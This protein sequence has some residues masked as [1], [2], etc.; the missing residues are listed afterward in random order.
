MAFLAMICLAVGYFLGVESGITL[1]KEEDSDL[2][3][4]NK[5]MAKINGISKC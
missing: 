4:L 3:K 5:K 2:V 1:Q